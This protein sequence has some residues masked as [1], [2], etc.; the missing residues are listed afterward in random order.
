MLSV[1]RLT[2]ETLGNVK[3][4]AD[5]VLIGEETM[6]RIGRYGFELTYLRMQ[7]AE[8]RSFPP[9]EG[10]APA[11]LIGKP[12]AAVFAAY[13]DD[14]RVVGVASVQCLPSGWAELCDIRVDA[15]HRRKGVATALI[16][17][18]ERFAERQGM[19]GLRV[20]A[21]ESNP[22]LCQFLQH[23]GFELQGLD[24]RAL[25]HTPEEREKPLMRRACALYFYRETEKG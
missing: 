24:R 25:I 4:L 11:D 13:A 10:F 14:E 16:A 5:A 19:H 23:N 6:L 21:S 18:C 1:R 8:W 12:E 2:E 22:V 3:L 17:A 15:S 20:T 7:S 9:S